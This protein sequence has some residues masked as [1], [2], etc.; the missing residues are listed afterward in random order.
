MAAQKIKVRVISKMLVVDEQTHERI[1][2]LSG[3][4]PMSQYL[5]ELMR[6]LAKDTPLGLDVLSG[7]LV[8][9]PN[10]YIGIIKRGILTCVWMGADNGDGFIHR[11]QNHQCHL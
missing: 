5:R 4:V 6:E 11:N 8:E 3:K 10:I 2:M 9:H 1:R 7:G